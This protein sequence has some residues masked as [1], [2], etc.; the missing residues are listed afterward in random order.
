[1]GTKGFLT[2][3]FPSNGNSSNCG[4]G[5]GRALPPAA[6]PEPF[7]IRVAWEEKR[8]KL[9]GNSG[10]QEGWFGPLARFRRSL[11]GLGSTHSRQIEI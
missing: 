7:S 9:L 4:I 5:G 3:F 6:A 8:R 2:G 1:M 11:V 10:L